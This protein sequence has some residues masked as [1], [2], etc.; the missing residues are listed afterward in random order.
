MSSNKNWIFNDGKILTRKGFN[1]LN[2]EIDIIDSNVRGVL[3]TLFGCNVGVK[4]SFDIC[5]IGYRVDCYEYHILINNQVAGSI[6]I[7]GSTC[8]SYWST[9]K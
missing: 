7:F 4:V 6:R 1:Y 2:P 8:S 9:T 5:E 3:K